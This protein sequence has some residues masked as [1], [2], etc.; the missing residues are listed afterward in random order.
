MSLSLVRHDQGKLPFKYLTLLVIRLFDRRMR[1]SRLEPIIV[2]TSLSFSLPE[3]VVR[4]SSFPR[5]TYPILAL[6]VLPKGRF[7]TPLFAFSPCV[8]LR[9]L[10]S[11]SAIPLTSFR[12]ELSFESARA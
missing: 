1:L 6:V 8:K 5:K 4:M 7:N 9:A 12:L 11:G 3:T 2:F 10:S